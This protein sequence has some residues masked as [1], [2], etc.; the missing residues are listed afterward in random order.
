MYAHRDDINVFYFGEFSRKE[1]I[2]NKA[3]FVRKH[4]KKNLDKL[5]IP[6]YKN[7]FFRYT[8]NVEKKDR[9]EING[10]CVIDFE[11]WKNNGCESSFGF[12]EA[13]SIMPKPDAYTYDNEPLF[14][15]SMYTRMFHEIPKDVK[16]DTNIY[17]Y[18]FQKL[19]DDWSYHKLKDKIRI[20]SK[21]DVS[22]KSPDCTSDTKLKKDSE[23]NNKKQ[24]KNDD[25][26]DFHVE[27][28]GM[29]DVNYEDITTENRTTIKD[30]TSLL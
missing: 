7:L 2:I 21:T 16:D 19:L 1:G 9:W 12:K 28:I 17:D 20:M 26:E 24:Q 8:E 22:K 27:E 14:R 29:K 6:F 18:S 11:K 25:H 5:W 13:Y 10:K 30:D 4:N 3:S 23:N 15:T